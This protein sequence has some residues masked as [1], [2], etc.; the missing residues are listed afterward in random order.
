GGSHLENLVLSDLVA[1]REL[2]SPRPNILFWRTVNGEEVDF[3]IERGSRLLPIEVKASTRPTHGDIR[4]LT[5]FREQYG[6]AV[7]GGILLHAGSE[8]F[9]LAKE[10]LATPWWRVI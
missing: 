8:T 9:W 7:R 4:H 10:I 6:R 2:V 5:T 3:V 1:W